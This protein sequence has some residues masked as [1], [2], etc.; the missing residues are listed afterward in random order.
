MSSITS[1]E[2]LSNELFYE[3]FD[4]LNVCD[5]CEA[6]SNLNYHFY[7]LLNS[8]SLLFKI[9]LDYTTPDEIYN[10]I[11]KKIIFC[12]KHQIFSLDLSLL[13]RTNQF[14]SSLTFNSSL[15]RLE[16]LAI[17]KI[18]PEMLFTILIN[19]A[20]LPRLFS[21]NLDPYNIFEDLN[22]VYRLIFNLPKLKYNELMLCGDDRPITL[23]MATNKQSSTIEHLIIDHSCT[24]KKLVCLVS[25]TPRLSRLN[26]LHVDY[27]DSNIGVFLLMTLSNLTH[28][29]MTVYYLMF[30]QLKMFIKNIN[31]TLKVLHIRTESEDINY[32]DATQSDKH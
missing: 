9:K 4:Y 21:L 18:E 14:F 17:G 19:L 28:L 3:I 25:Y 29:F 7:Q 30:D 15:Y 32:L 8:S 31:S 26:F 24:F 20:D 13:S 16:S 2:N 5:M 22:E 23:P 6:F 1:I 11:S 10:N 27:D 12:N